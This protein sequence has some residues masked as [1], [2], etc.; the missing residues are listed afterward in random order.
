MDQ[1]IQREQS[2]YNQSQKYLSKKKLEDDL[3]IT[4]EFQLHLFNSMIKNINNRRNY[5]K[6]QI[7]KLFSHQCKEIILIPGKSNLINKFNLVLS[8]AYRR[9]KNH[10]GENNLNTICQ[11][12]WFQLEID[13]INNLFK[14]FCQEFG[15]KKNKTCLLFGFRNQ[16]NKSIPYKCKTIKHSHSPF[17]FED[18]DDIKYVDQTK[19]STKFYRHLLPSINP[20]NDLIIKLVKDPN[21]NLTNHNLNSYQYY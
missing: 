14:Y 13:I 6:N 11:N 16:L 18:V 3:K 17:C 20:K 9:F 15:I 19:T 5:I 4:A 10:Q 12:I 2:K 8:P 1:E 7:L 21:N